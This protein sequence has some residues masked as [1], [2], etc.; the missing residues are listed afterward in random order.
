M[1]PEEKEAMIQELKQKLAELEYTPEKK[2]QISYVSQQ[3][4]RQNIDNIRTVE[5]TIHLAT[6]DEEDIANKLKII[7]RESYSA[8]K[9]LEKDIA[10]R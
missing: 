8:L 1:T 7:N 6:D 10:E 2:N 3:K 9:I 4:M 5:S